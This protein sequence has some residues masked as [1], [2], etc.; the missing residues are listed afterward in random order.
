[1]GSWNPCLEPGAEAGRTGGVK[2]AEEPAVLLEVCAV[3]SG[4]ME[5]EVQFGGTVRRGQAQTIVKEGFSGM[6]ELSVKG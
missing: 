5:G 6:L 1:M 2:Q 4:N 3:C